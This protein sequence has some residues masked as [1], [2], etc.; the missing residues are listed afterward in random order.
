MK[1][2]LFL[3]VFIGFGVQ[4]S[5]GQENIKTMF[6]NLLN[7]SSAPPENRTEILNDILANYE[8]DIF[9]V[10]E[11]ELPQDASQILTNSFNYT[12]ANIQSVPF[13]FNTSGISSIHQLVYY[14]A[15]KLTLIDSEIIQTNVR[16]IN[17]YQF[18]LNTN[19]ETI[20]DVFVA[21]FKA[22]QGFSN[23][24][25]RLFEANQFVNYVGNLPQN[26]NIIFGG[27]FN[28]Y[29]AFEPA[30]Q[31][32]TEGTQNIDFL[33]PIDEIG[34]WNNNSQFA[35]VHTQSTRSSNNDFEDF[36]AGGGLDDRFDFIFISDNLKNQNNPV[37]YVENSYAAFGN[38][39]NCF[40]DNISDTDCFGVYNQE[41]RNLLY[42]MSDH[43]PVVMSLEIDENFLSKKNFQ[44]EDLI[45]FSNGN[46][47]K[48]ILALNF[49]NNV[50]DKKISIYNALGQEF[51]Q[52]NVKSN[53]VEIDVSEYSVGVYFLK[54][55]GINH[56][57]K[58]LKSN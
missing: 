2:I 13:Q 3:I 15:D 11:L 49:N 28:L 36:G 21:H 32:I 24:Q 58:F 6:Y 42:L 29:S 44:L 38:N 50:Q 48:D 5:F 56:A 10:C 40:N 26:S 1:K 4:T 57:L 19:S 54:L 17:H 35:Q 55:E 14:D 43:L 47:V 25:Q 22:A 23:E 8:P 41:L 46:I 9:M 31:T 7:F 34:A 30:F 45:S 37:R 52:S 12:T 27:D 20:L 51:Y 33:D 16:D 18:Q 39:G 53:D